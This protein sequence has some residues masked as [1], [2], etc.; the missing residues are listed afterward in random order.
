MRIT[1][2]SRARSAVAKGGDPWIL[3][4]SYVQSGPADPWIY[5]LTVTDTNGTGQSGFVP[6]YKLKRVQPQGAWYYEF[7]YGDQEF[8]FT[9]CTTAAAM[10]EAGQEPVSPGERRGARM[11]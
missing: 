7:G 3:T 4:G 1:N 2:T 6:M 9:S 5:E 11:G 8:T 10:A